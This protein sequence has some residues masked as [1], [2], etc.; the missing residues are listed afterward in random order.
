MSLK[1]KNI[2]YY[3]AVRGLVMVSI[4]DALHDVHAIWQESHD[5]RVLDNSL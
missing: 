3:C 4:K 5:V 1:A 2:I